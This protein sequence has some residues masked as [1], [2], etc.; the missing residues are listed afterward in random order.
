[1]KSNLW[2]TFL[3]GHTFSVKMSQR[4]VIQKLPFYIFFFI[5]IIF[6]FYKL[7]CS[8]GFYINCINHIFQYLQKCICSPCGQQR[9]ISQTIYCYLLRPYTRKLIGFVSSVHQKHMF[10]YISIYIYFSLKNYFF[11]K[12]KHPKVDKVIKV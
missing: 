9:S 7:Y 6:F 11:Y 12:L 3:S 4:H 5:I 1:M 8:P 10:L 2:N